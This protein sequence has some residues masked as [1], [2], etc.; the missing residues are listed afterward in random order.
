MSRSYSRGSLSTA[1][2][3][4]AAGAEGAGGGVAQRGDGG[5]GLLAGVDEV[6][7]ERADDAVAAGEHGADGV[8][9]L[10]GRLDDPAGG[11]VDDGGDPAGL[12][13]E[14]VPLGHGR[15]GSSSIV[16]ST[17]A[18]LSASCRE[19]HRATPSADRVGR[20]AA[21]KPSTVA[22]LTVRPH[23]LRSSLGVLHSSRGRSS[24]RSGSW[25]PSRHI[26]ELRLVAV[27]L[28]DLLGGLRRPAARGD[29]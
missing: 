19:G 29:P 25:A 23:Y 11:G 3:L 26:G 22:L 12:R 15:F 16:V 28:L 27:G 6:L 2:E 7:G 18:A 10:A 17:D 24:M 1:L 21:V 14:G 4:V 5:V 9:V 8:G 20:R 13:V